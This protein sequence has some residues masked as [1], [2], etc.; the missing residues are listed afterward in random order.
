MEDIDY[1]AYMDD[2]CVQMMDDEGAAI[3]WYLMARYQRDVKE[4]DLV[5]GGVLARLENHLINSPEEVDESPHVDIFMDRM[6]VRD[7]P[8]NIELALD[9]LRKAICKH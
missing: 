5:S 4:K 9:Q 8:K 6:V 3:K 1:I 2:T 7:Y